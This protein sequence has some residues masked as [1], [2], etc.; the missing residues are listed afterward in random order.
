[1]ITTQS[2]EDGRFTLELRR[3]AEKRLPDL[4][5]DLVVSSVYPIVLSW[6]DEG[7][8]SGFDLSFDPS[9]TPQEYERYCADLLSGSG[10]FTRLTPGSGDQGADII[11]E[12]EGFRMVV[13]C[14]LYSSPVGNSAV[15]EAIAA[16]AF[17]FADEAVVVTNAEF[18]RSARE[19][20]NVS[21]VLLLHHEQLQDLR[22][23]AVDETHEG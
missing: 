9:M 4:D 20:A 7:S 3:F 10:W 6:L 18:T 14:K 13:Q 15:Q 16:K 21:G 2:I 23:K 8:D 5:S 22:P 19:L 11:C 1:M 12:Y 17:E